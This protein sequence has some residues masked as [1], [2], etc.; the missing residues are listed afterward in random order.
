MLNN[1]L[2]YYHINDTFVEL[3]IQVAKGKL[4]TLTLPKVSVSKYL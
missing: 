2:K 3:T 1:L 4:K